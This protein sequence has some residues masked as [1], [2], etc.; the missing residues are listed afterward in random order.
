MVVCC[1]VQQDGR[2]PTIWDIFSHT[3]GKTYE[4]ETGDVADD[5]YNK[6]RTDID[7]M[8]AMNVN[9]F[10]FSIA[11]SRIINEDN[12]VNHAGIAHYSALIDGLL[13]ASITPWVR[14]F[15]DICSISKC[16]CTYMCVCMA[17]W[18]GCGSVL[19]ASAM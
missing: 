18:C 15:D 14:L 1:A 5:S 9:A 13:A 8:S 4:G 6:W 19:D 7:L 10:R 17:G 11:W 3:P 16:M 12:T 2:V